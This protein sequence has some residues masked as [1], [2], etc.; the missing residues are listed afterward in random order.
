MTRRPPSWRF[1]LAV[2]LCGAFPFQAR[3]FR[4]QDHRALTQAALDAAV[5]SGA[6]AGLAE[7]RG[8]VVHGATAEDWNLHVKWTGWHHF[9]RPEGAL[10]SVLRRGSEDRVRA[11]W[12]DALEAARN[13]DL[14]RAWDRAGHLAHHL[15]DMASPPHVVPVNHG[16][17]DGFERYGVGA[18]LKRLPRRE[19]SP[20]SGTDAQRALARE[21][22]E[23][24]RTGTLATQ[25]GGALPWSAFWS[26]PD[27]ASP[28]AFG[29]YGPVGNAFGRGEVRWKGTR[30]RIPPAGPAAFMDDRVASAVAYSGAFLAW[31]AQRFEEVS[32]PDAAFV[33]LR[34]FQP[35]PELSLEALGGIF[36][37]ARG[38][39]PVVGLRGSLPLPHGLGL[40]VDWTR[41]LE[42][43]AAPRARPVGGWAFSVLSPPLIAWRPGYAW[44]VDVRALAGVGLRTWE[45]GDTR[46]GVPVGLR[47]HVPLGANLVASTEVLYQGLRPPGVTWAHGFTWSLGFG[48]AWGDR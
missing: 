30:Q 35:S 26:E 45:G 33:A 15:Q 28:G 11:L 6:G 3:A 40:S 4:V 13:G 16:L 17:S 18:S 2:L 37:D 24:V 1:L 36:S 47:A 19:V 21:T 14:P 9:Y 32:A 27:S 7:H 8:Q 34:A 48:V 5:A 31:A 23:A 41:G 20:M 42:G 29:V 46:L 12:D 22:L 25:D 43:G 10:S 39:A 38:T 44:G